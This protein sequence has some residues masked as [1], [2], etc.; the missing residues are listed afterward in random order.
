[1]TNKGVTLIELLIVIVVLGII[2]AFSS[3]M[4]TTIIK[5]T[6]ED[7]FVNT[8]TTMIHSASSAYSKNESLWDDNVATLQELIDNDYIDISLKDPWGEL[9][10]T[11]N[12]FVTIGTV[13]LI[14]TGE[15]FLSNAV[16]LST[17][18]VF[19]VTLVSV[20]ATIG[21][22]IPLE[23]FENN[24]VVYFLNEVSLINGI[25]E[26]ITGN[27]SSS[28]T[29]DNNNDSITV[30]GNAL[31]NARINTFDGNDNITVS[32]D[33]KGNAAIDAGIG[34]D[35]IDVGYLRGRSKINGGPGNDTIT[36]YEIRFRTYIDAGTGDDTITVSSVTNNYKGSVIMGTGND[37]LTLKD[38]SNIFAGVN[39]S[40]NG[41]PGDDVLNLPDVDTARWNQISSMFS[42]FETIIL[43]DGTITN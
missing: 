5:K 13:L 35:T 12:S 27:L 11:T 26:S 6:K 19:K 14:P 15:V 42:N 40:F 17:G 21:Y 37:T 7:S 39:G 41:G 33:M 8:A 10:D 24:D 4:V 29:G 28:I 2:A 36:C 38:P 1:M 9:Y 32:G 30:D 25:I 43:K 22:D 23:E 3:V 16:Y 18:E 34:N 20:T 31:S